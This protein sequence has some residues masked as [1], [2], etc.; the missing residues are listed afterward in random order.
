M[1]YGILIVDN[2]LKNRE[3]TLVEAKRAK[4]QNIRL[5]IIAVGDRVQPDKLRQLCS[6]QRDYFYVENYSKLADLKIQLIQTICEGKDQTVRPT[7]SPSISFSAS[8]SINV[9][10]PPPNNAV[11]LIHRSI[12]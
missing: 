5:I 2:R 10:P 12:L 4:E 8:V 9:D 6:S 1:K 3:Q 7:L 11:V